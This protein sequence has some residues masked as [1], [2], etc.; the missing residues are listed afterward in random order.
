VIQIW[1]RVVRGVKEKDINSWRRYY[2]TIMGACSLAYALLNTFYGKPDVVGKGIATFTCGWLPNTGDKRFYANTIFEIICFSVAITLFLH[3]VYVCVK[4]SLSVVDTEKKPLKKIWKSYSMIFLFLALHLILY[5]IT[6]F[7]LHVK[8]YYVDSP[9]MADSELAWYT[10]LFQNFVR[11]DNEGYLAVCGDVPAN[12]AGFKA[13]II[14]EPI[15]YFTS[16]VLL[17]ITLYKEVREFWHAMFLR[18]LA[19]AGVRFLALSVL[20]KHQAGFF[21]IA[22]NRA[23]SVFSSSGGHSDIE[24]EEGISS[25]KETAKP[26]LASTPAPLN[27]FAKPGVPRSDSYLP[28]NYAE[29]QKLDASLSEIATERNSARE[30]EVEHSH[31]PRFTR[32]CAEGSGDC[33]VED[34]ESAQQRRVPSTGSSRHNVNV[35]DTIHSECDAANNEHSIYTTLPSFNAAA[36]ALV[37]I[38]M[39]EAIARSEAAGR[40]G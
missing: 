15:I 8:L 25:K 21:T 2:L 17:Y 30:S 33:N 35:P 16:L 26:T 18:F 23:S 5:S 20:G 6:V 11:S 39:N 37:E 1:L 32:A 27:P 7:Y 28:D 34:I 24:M 19:F 12:R 36:E 14:E 29:L 3:V 40:H 9:K 13:Y 31:Q 10:C 38:A 4:T 22:R